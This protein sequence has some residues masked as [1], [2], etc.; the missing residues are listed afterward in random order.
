MI[1]QQIQKTDA[2]T[3]IDNARPYIVPFDHDG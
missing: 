3:Q 1:I 2:I